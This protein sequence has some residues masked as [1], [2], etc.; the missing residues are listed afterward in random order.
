MPSLV[1]L[2]YARVVFVVSESTGAAANLDLVVVI[3][4]LVPRQSGS[5]W[6]EAGGVEE[7]ANEVAYVLESTVHLGAAVAD[8]CSAALGLCRYDRSRPGPS[9]HVLSVGWPVDLH[10]VPFLELAHA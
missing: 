4:D 2:M 3:L 9:G 5:S 6:A 8:N 10:D 7:R 1:G